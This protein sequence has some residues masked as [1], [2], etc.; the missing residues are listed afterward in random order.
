MRTVRAVTLD[1]YGT[2]FEF[3]GCL[4]VVAEQIFALDRAEGLC[5]HDFSRAW[6]RNFG[7]LYEEFGR[8][9]RSAGLAF[10]TVA[11]ITADSLE[12]T[13]REHGLE[14][15]P[16]PGTRL[17]ISRLFEV[18]TY[19]EVPAVLDTLSGRAEL[20]MLSD[21]DDHIIAPA[22]ERLDWPFSFVLTSE[23]VGAYKYD[24]EATI[25]RRALARLGLPGHAVL[26]VGDSA[27]DVIGARLAGM[28]VVWVN[29]A[30]RELPAGCPRP[31]AVVADLSEIPAL[32]G[33]AS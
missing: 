9:F 18:E 11:E 31:D 1:A 4:P 21:T 10:K 29:R 5:P 17:W 30:G 8:T 23:S 33:V 16:W 7:A 3:E 2:V 25:F 14:R 15:D 20:A 27:A 24:P 6:S 32:L 12:A 26:H 13:Y 22:L 19:P 28:R